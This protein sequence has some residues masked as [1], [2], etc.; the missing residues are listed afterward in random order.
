M[1]RTQKTVK[2]ARE[3]VAMKKVIEDLQRGPGAQEIMEAVQ[4][5]LKPLGFEVASVELGEQGFGAGELTVRAIRPATK[6]ITIDSLTA[7][8]KEV[9]KLPDIDVDSPAPVFQ[10]GV[11]SSF[12]GTFVEQ[13]LTLEKE[14]KATVTAVDS[15]PD[16]FFLG[17]ADFS[18]DPAVP[19]A[20]I[21]E[22]PGWFLAGQELREPFDYLKAGPAEEGRAL[23]EK[24]REEFQR[25]TVAVN[26]A[27]RV[28]YPLGFRL[29]PKPCECGAH[30][31]SGVPRGAGHSEWCPWRQE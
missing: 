30:K 1:G 10:V 8:G 7:M 12:E 4:Q 31:A 18:D 23:A 28:A 15:D 3:A 2:R 22:V 21:A 16:G 26:N 24:V 6:F 5:V 25:A 14:L 13:H 9:P 20:V 17:K 29:E 11:P 19:N 27:W